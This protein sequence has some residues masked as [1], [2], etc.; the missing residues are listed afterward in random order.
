MPVGGGFVVDAVGEV[1]VWVDVFLV[2]CYG[3]VGEGCA[4]GASANEM[5]SLVE[6]GS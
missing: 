5:R 1:G 3:G 6:S 4:G 2:F